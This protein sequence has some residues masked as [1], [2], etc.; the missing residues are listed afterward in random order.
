MPSFTR[1]A[2]PFGER[3]A[4]A[5]NRMKLTSGDLHVGCARRW[6]DGGARGVI[7]SPLAAYPGVIW[8]TSE[9]ARGTEGYSRHDQQPRV[10]TRDIIDDHDSRHRPRFALRWSWRLRG[11]SSPAGLFEA[12]HSR[13]QSG[14]SRRLHSKASRRATPPSSGGAANDEPASPSQTQAIRRILRHRCGHDCPFPHDASRSPQAGASRCDATPASEA[15]NS[16]LGRSP[17]GHAGRAR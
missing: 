9:A 1:F 2:W 10:S 8:T 7:E 17:A 13:G 11:R 14:V 5:N 12:R 3:E 6:Q 15:Y 4:R 16:R